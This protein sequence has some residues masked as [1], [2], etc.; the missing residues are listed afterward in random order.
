MGIG[1]LKCG[2]KKMATNKQ[3][4]IKERNMKFCPECEAEEVSRLCKAAEEGNAQAQYDLGV[5]YYWGRGAEQ[6]LAK[7]AEYFRKAAEQDLSEAQY[8]LGWCYHHGEGV[9]EDEAEALKLWHKAAEQG[10]AEA[11]CRLGDCYYWGFD[12]KQDKAEGIKWFRKAAAQGSAYAKKWLKEHKAEV[13]K[14]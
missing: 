11:Q 2:L 3:Y 13:D 7:A 6:D 1:G 9:A 8:H 12:A 5:C 4:I 14:Y 10:Y